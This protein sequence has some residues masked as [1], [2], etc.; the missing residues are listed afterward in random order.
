MAT[1]YDVP[2]T[3]F[4][5]K[6]KDELKTIKELQPP[7]WSLY[8]KTGVHKQRPPEQEDWW[9]Y[10]AASILYQIYRRGIIGVGK[11]RNYYGSRKDRGH[12][13]EKKVRAGAK[14]IRAI[15]QQLERAGLVEKYGIEHPKLHVVY[16]GR[17]LTSAGQSLID[18]VATRIAKE[19]GILK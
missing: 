15:L 2:I 16:K 5:E 19:L 10:R 11:L 12:Q 8:V 14:I 4:I 18:R 7:E 6:L 17:K 3:L 9:Y 13:P 1:P